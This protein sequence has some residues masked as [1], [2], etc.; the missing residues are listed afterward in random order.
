MD[1]ELTELDTWRESHSLFKSGRLGTLQQATI[2]WDAAYSASPTSPSWKSVPSLGG[3][4][5]NTFGSHVFHYLEWFFGPLSRLQA[6][7]DVSIVKSVEIETLTLKCLFDSGLTSGIKITRNMEGRSL[8]RIDVTGDRG[9]L[10]LSNETRD[11]VA[12]FSLSATLSDGARPR[13]LR[14]TILPNGD[15]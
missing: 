9:T 8:H 13:V 11:V 1:F 4:L 5:L 3:G 2:V 15:G 10:S 6:Q 14:E 7:R 12:G